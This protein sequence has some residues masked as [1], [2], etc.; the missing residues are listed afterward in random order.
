MQIAMWILIS[1]T[2]NNI[3][4]ASE[5]EAALKMR[6]LMT[7]LGPCL[8]AFLSCHSMMGSKKIV[9]SKIFFGSPYND[10][11]SRAAA[12]MESA[13]GSAYN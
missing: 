4:S 12:V 5:I 2:D 10:L 13:V 8:A 3:F 1:Q 11:S 7:S 9:S 6:L